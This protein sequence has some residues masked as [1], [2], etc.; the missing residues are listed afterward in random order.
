MCNSIQNS[1]I[2]YVC[3]IYVRRKL[4][5][6]ISIHRVV[7]YL[8]CQYVYNIRIILLT[9][10]LLLKQIN[11]LSKIS[12]NNKNNKKFS[13]RSLS[14]WN[15]Q[16]IS[17]WLVIILMTIFFFI[18]LLI[19]FWNYFQWIILLLVVL[20]LLFPNSVELLNHHNH[21]MDMRDM[22]MFCLSVCLSIHLSVCDID[23]SM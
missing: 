6:S 16:I 22:G 11:N 19:F 14:P 13:F 20:L 5:T 17:E 2:K 15:F 8:L 23:K 18:L 7:D 12:T 4:I 1:W 10:C 3:Q 21:L 9:Y